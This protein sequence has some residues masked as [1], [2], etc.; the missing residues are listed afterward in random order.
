MEVSDSVSSVLW[1]KFMSSLGRKGPCLPSK[2]SALVIQCGSYS[3][4]G[5]SLP[6]RLE[7]LNMLI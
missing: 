2:Y 6:T 7:S 1:Q 4:V 3:G 5:L